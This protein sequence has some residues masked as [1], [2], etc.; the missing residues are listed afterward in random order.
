M[1]T[2][3][4]T[5]ARYFPSWHSKETACDFFDIK[6]VAEGLL[7]SLNLVNCEFTSLPE[8]FCTYTRPGH[9]AQV[10]VDTTFI[11][12]VGEV[13]PQTLQNFDLAQTAFILELDLERLTACLPETLQAQPIPKFP[14]TT[15]DI[16]I[17]V[18]KDIESQK[19]VNTIE[20]AHEDLIERIQLFDVYEGTPIAAGK[21]SISFRIVYRSPHKTLEDEEI[22]RLNKKITDR[23]VDEF[24]ATLPV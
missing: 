22:N 3:L 14:A 4:W 21:K 24:S 13:H 17:I 18:N 7:K 9:T 5:G 6:G 11:G 8:A 15:R 1:L 2:A 16:T 19:I 10:M 23:L 20:S 12:L